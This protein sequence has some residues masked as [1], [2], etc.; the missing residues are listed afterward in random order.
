MKECEDFDGLFYRFCADPGS[1]EITEDVHHCEKKASLA[2]I[3]RKP[4]NS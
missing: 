3:F 4:E 2:G 1:Q